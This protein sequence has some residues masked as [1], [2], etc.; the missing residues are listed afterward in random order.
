[1]SVLD[2][3]Q[4]LPPKMELK[5]VYLGGLGDAKTELSAHLR[6]R[7]KVGEILAST[8]IPVI[9]FQPV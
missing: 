4:K 9:E 3:L 8:G 6:S 7:Q 5:I 1:M 2:I